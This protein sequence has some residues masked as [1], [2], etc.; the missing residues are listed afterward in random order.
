MNDVATEISTPTS[1]PPPSEL[2]GAAPLAQEAK[3]APRRAPLTFVEK[4][5][6]M[7]DQKVAALEKVK[8]RELAQEAEL[9]RTQ[10]AR[11]AIE[12]ELLGIERA[13]LEAD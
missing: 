4:L 6:R 11:A 12:R 8:T 9:S 3:S 7:R 13:R 2:N 1:E 10:Q 5:D